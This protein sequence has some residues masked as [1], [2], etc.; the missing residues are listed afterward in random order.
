[1]ALSWGDDIS[2]RVLDAYLTTILMMKCVCLSLM[3]I[4]LNYCNASNMWKANYNVWSTRC[5]CIFINTS[6]SFAVPIGGERASVGVKTVD[7]DKLELLST[8]CFWICLDTL[9]KQMH[10]RKLSQS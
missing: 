9:R 2:V 7:N 10:I 6:D 1:M 3:F 4:A 5:K 8:G